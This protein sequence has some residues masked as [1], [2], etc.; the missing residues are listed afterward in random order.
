MREKLQTKPSLRKWL[1]LTD[2]DIA[3][4]VDEV[5]PAIV[6]L[7]P[8]T[9]TA[10]GA[11]QADPDDDIVVAAALESQAEY[12]ISE[13]RHLLNLGLYGGIKIL[14]RDAFHVELN[15]LGVP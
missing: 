5:L 15:Q 14:S 2:A 6:R 10:P 3:I 1:N 12:I 7:Y 9:V 8:G 4:F 13:D 11:V